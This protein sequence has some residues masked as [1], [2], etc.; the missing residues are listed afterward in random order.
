VTLPSPPPATSGEQPAGDPEDPRALAGMTVLVVDDEPDAREVARRIL[1]ERGAA[2]MVAASG[3]EALRA[4]DARTPSVIV[5][6]IG[7]PGMDGY[8]LVRRV[9][10]ARDEGT[11]SV[12]AVALTA[13]AREE[14]RER[15]LA[16]GYQGHVAKPISAGALVAAVREACR[17]SVVLERAS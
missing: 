14:D 7:M 11:S 5:S 6:D 16:V 1:E 3:P 13:Y 17:S 12:P 15:A 9:R 2:V 10:A 4:I 8:E